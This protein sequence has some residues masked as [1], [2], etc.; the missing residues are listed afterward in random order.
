MTNGR[1]L[2]YLDLNEIPFSTWV[3]VS[4]EE[5][6][7]QS[8]KK[9]KNQNKIKETYLKYSPTQTCNTEQEILELGEKTNL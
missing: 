6:S 1:G 3:L 2:I 4:S 9:K 5:M 8:E 7:S